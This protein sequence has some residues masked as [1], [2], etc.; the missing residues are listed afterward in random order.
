MFFEWD[1]DNGEINSLDN[2]VTTYFDAAGFYQ[3]SLYVE[4][5]IGCFDQLTHEIEVVE[6]FSIFVPKNIVPIIA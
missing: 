5:E 1:F 2:V 6:E 4:N 3:I